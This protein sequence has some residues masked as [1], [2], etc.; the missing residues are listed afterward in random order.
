MSDNF[1]KIVKA[2]PKVFL[3]V[4]VLLFVMQIVGFF[5]IYFLSNQLTK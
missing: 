4:F 2:L 1:F 3:A 5:M